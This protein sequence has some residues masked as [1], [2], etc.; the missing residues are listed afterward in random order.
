M[1]LGVQFGQ[2][3]Q[4]VDGGFSD[5]SHSSSLNNVTDNK[6]LNCL[7]LRDTASTVGATDRVHMTPAVLGTASVTAF[8]SH[9]VTAGGLD[10]DRLFCPAP[11]GHAPQRADRRLSGATRIGPDTR[12]QPDRV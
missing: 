9:F 3:V 8:G 7:I 5:I 6:L 10:L 4:A 1:Q 11:A 2:L 12:A